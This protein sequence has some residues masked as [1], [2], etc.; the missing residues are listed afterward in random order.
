MRIC[1]A[2][3]VSVRP[4]GYL[5]RALAVPPAQVGQGQA[6]RHARA[7]SFFVCMLRGVGMHPRQAVAQCITRLIKNRDVILD[8]CCS[9]T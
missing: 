2:S 3:A 9:D 7:V 1:V 8:S 5:H 4:K 6:A